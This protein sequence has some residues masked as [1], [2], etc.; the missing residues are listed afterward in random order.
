[1]LLLWIIMRT[2]MTY[3]GTDLVTPH[4]QAPHAHALAAR[5]APLSAQAAH[6]DEA[7][8]TNILHEHLPT[9]T[10]TKFAIGVICTP[11]VARSR[12]KKHNVSYKDDMHRLRC[13]LTDS[14]CRSVNKKVLHC[15]M[16]LG[17]GQEPRSRSFY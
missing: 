9:K 17:L 1:M 7:S 2:Y 12:D 11:S 5:A 3:N 4:T 8:Q 14:R 15:N 16:P 6:A 10:A 13:V